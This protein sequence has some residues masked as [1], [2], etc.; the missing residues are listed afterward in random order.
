MSLCAQYQQSLKC[1][2]NLEDPEKPVPIGNTGWVYEPKTGKILQDRECG[3]VLTP[4]CKD[5]LEGWGSCFC[6]DALEQCKEV[7]LRPATLPGDQQETVEF[8]MV[9]ERCPPYRLRLGQYMIL[10]KYVKATS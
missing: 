4:Y 1:A 9:I 7:R 3:L 10:C 6:K 8:A 2:C 5:Y